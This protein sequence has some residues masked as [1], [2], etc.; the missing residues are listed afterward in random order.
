MAQPMRVEYVQFY[1]YGSTARKLELLVPG[2]PVA[3]PKAKPQVQ[4]RKRVYVD[5]VAIFG[6][7]V[8]VCMLI[9]MFI[10]LHQLQLARQETVVMEA[11]VMQLQKENDS[12]QR[13]Y[14]DSFNLEDIEKT[15][16][17]LGMVPMSEV[18]HSTIDVTEPVQEQEATTWETFT[19]FLTNLFA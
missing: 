2:K 3:A 14:R 9:T 13:Q 18:N 19:T 17:A 1:T 5:P 7:I 11:Y 8:A 16:V 4:K 12:Y 10:G 6:V 15:A